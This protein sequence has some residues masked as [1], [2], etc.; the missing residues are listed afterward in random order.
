[1][2]AGTEF[3]R[4]LEIAHRGVEVGDEFLGRGGLSINLKLQ[5]ESSGTHFG[6]EGKSSSQLTCGVC[7]A[8]VRMSSDA[9]CTSARVA[10]VR[11]RL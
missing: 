10:S 7:A 4:R 5:L 8:R 11:S 9:R 2:A 6:K 3:L 1:L